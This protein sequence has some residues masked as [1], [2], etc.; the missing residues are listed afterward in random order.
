MTPCQLTNGHVEYVPGERITAKRWTSLESRT[1]LLLN[2]PA[3]EYRGLLWD[4]A[5]WVMDGEDLPAFHPDAPSANS[6]F[7]IIE[8]E[9]PGIEFRR[10]YYNTI[11]SG[12]Y[13]MADIDRLP[14]GTRLYQYNEWSDYLNRVAAAVGVYQGTAAH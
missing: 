4:A 10:F 12:A 8:V 7:P 1:W 3:A 9:E 14:P 2:V 11:L 6:H 5:M 13:L